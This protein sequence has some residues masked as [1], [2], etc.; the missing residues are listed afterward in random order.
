[1]LIFSSSNALNNDINY[2]FKDVPYPY[3]G[4]KD[5]AKLLIRDLLKEHLNESISAPF[6]NEYEQLDDIREELPNGWKIELNEESKQ[7]KSTLRII[8]YNTY[9][10]ADRNSGKDYGSV[11]LKARNL[12]GYIWVVSEVLV[13]DEGNEEI[14]LELNS[15]QGES[16][17]CILLCGGDDGYSGDIFSDFDELDISHT[18]DGIVISEESLNEVVNGMFD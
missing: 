18:D 14:P 6:F 2:V 11:K 17:V 13:D 15:A 4:T 12:C 9:E 8:I 16:P 10:E 3:Q 1:M 5:E 7:P